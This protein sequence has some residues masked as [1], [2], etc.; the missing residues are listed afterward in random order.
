M[1]K[2]TLLKALSGTLD[3]SNYQLRKESEQQLKVYEQQPGFTAY[4][5]ELCN[6]DSIS[7]GIQISAAIL[8]KN[9][10]NNYW[11]IN[12][13][14]YLPI[15][16]KED[17][18]HLIKNKLIE[19]L[20]KTN[21]NNKIK[22]QLST[23]INQI[24]NLE[25]WD[26]LI[27]IIK[28]L[29]ISDDID[30]INA[31]LICLYQYTKAYRFSH[32]EGANSSN[33]ILEEITV[34]TFPSLENLLSNLL[35]N[36]SPVTDEMMYL[37]TK[38]FKFTTFSSLPSYLQN[39][40]NLSKWCNYQIM[41]INKPL[42]DYVMKVQEDERMTLFRIKAVKWC[43]GNL[44][45]FLS[46][47]GGGFATRDKSENQFS[48]NFLK[49][50]VPEILKV[51][52][53]IIENWS[54]K[55]I[56]LSES[57]LYHMISFLEQLIEN[58]G[59]N[60]IS[61]EMNAILSHVILPTLSA[62]DET[63]EL[64]EDDP[65]EYYRRF[66]DIN[67]ESNN[68]DVA[69]ISFVYRLSS[70]KFDESSNLLLSLI[71]DIFNQR[72]KDKN[73][74]SIAKKVEGAFRI[75]STISYKLDKKKS[76]VHDQVDQLLYTF[77]YP[78]LLDE[79]I[80]KFPFLT[81]RACD[82]IAMFI[83]S[84]KDTKVLQ[85]IFTG[86]VNCF[87]KQDHLP[88]RLTAV[89]A[90]RTLVDN[91]AV[92]EHISPQVPQLMGTL[93]EMSKTIESDTL[94]SIMESFV[95]KF[96][97]SL[98]PYA[99]DLCSKLS[100][101][102]LRLAHELLEMQSSNSG[103]TDMDKEYQASGIINTITTLVVAMSTSPS[104]ASSL[105]PGLKDLITFVI[106]NAQV[107][108]L[109]ETMEI[110][111]SLVVTNQ[112]VSPIIWECYSLVMEAFDTYAD[113]FFDNFEAFFDAIICYGFNNR[114]IGIDNQYVQSL[115]TVCF[116][117]LKSDAVDPVFAN[118]SFEVLEL[119]IIGLGDRFKPF[120]TRFLTEIYG[121]F[122]ELK[123]Q[124]AFDGYMLHYLSIIRTF[125]ST[126]IVDPNTTLEFLNQQNFTNNFFKLWIEH[127]SDFQSVYGCK[128]Q[129]LTSL[130]ILCDGNLT[131]INGDLVG[132][133]I[134]LLISNV[135]VLPV[136]I[137]TKQ[138]LQNRE[139]GVK[140]NDDEDEN[141]LDEE[142]EVDDAELEAMKI[143]PIDGVN[144]F[145]AFVNKITGLQQQNPTVYQ[146][147]ISRLDPDQQNIVNSVFQTHSTV[148]GN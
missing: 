118:S 19:T 62:N 87:Q 105:E 136:A 10:I 15:S 141:Y 84:Y 140:F 16:I 75:L 12:D 112:N 7:P 33:P 35:N 107:A 128:L 96:A 34:E 132:E 55:K 83:Y 26:E 61:N 111:E 76:P 4:L 147:F 110:L 139:Y 6:D 5:L 31:G 114:N 54:V 46:R 122:I 127:S 109:P 2:E 142:F 1:D 48:K 59:W 32:L 102:F 68:S 85:D 90:L 69:S 71:N 145:E 30:H 60:L 98:E 88:I 137:K 104:V 20:I 117:I 39:D 42:P 119:I 131:L 63:I 94:T 47:H 103:G 38:I 8:F 17:E 106:Q 18:K 81:A 53:T 95:E 50:F 91:D 133:L 86:V 138:E 120:L 57:S 52:W 22:L 70:K 72:A 79:T 25:K 45:R 130:S 56:W 80:S 37:I 67:R 124:D 9:R 144:V 99:V 115:I 123:N 100:E 92:A 64:Y 40:E 13:N 108:F 82:T 116:K 121:I 113:E 23:A 93:I 51:Y 89:D 73:D 3:A 74:I 58:E 125:F 41:L 78:E 27:E 49:T 24:V 129:I 65:E 11:I 77:V 29:I 134:D 43:F 135:E 101:Q 44:H 148:R 28:K 14:K 143:T 36:D 21:K 66:F 97:T 126:L 146:E